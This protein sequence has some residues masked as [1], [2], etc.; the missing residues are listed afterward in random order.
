MKA[1]LKYKTI[2]KNK[3]FWLL[4]MGCLAIDSLS[5][6]CRVFLIDRAIHDGL[7]QSSATFAVSFVGI[8]SAVSML[9]VQHPVISNSAKSRQ[10]SFGIST[11]F[12]SCVNIVSSVTPLCKSLVGFSIY[13]ALSG[14]FL[15]ISS[16]LWYLCI[17]D[18]VPQDLVIQAFSLQCFISGPFVMFSVPM[19]GFIYDKTGSYDGP[20]IIYSCIGLI[21][22][23]CV[24]SISYSCK[25]CWK[26]S[27]PDGRV[28]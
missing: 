6:G 2:L 28:I 14:V 13:C 23:F 26:N 9:G 24:A 12:W 27:H 1:L 11:F 20:Y 17:P 19:G 21:G 18:V 7:S 16:V 8:T 15:G 10:L 25:Y 4:A 22:A 3:S 5:N